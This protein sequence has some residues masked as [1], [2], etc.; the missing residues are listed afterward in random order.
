MAP[1]LFNIGIGCFRPPVVQY[2]QWTK[3]DKHSVSTVNPIFTPKEKKTNIIFYSNLC[4][5]FNGTKMI[6]IGITFCEGR[7]FLFF[8]RFIITIVEG[9]KL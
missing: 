7:G 1:Y 6:L 9:S 4:Y 3:Q 8:E 2:V 5:I